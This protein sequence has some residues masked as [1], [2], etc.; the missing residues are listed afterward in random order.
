MHI[1][2]LGE[3]VSL[4]TAGGK[5]LNLCLLVEAGFNVPKGFIIATSA[6]NEYVEANGL[7]SIIDEN[8]AIIDDTV[9][10]LQTASEHIRETFTQGKMPE[11]LRKTIIEAYQRHEVDKVA[12]R[13]SATAE[14]LPETS[15]AGQQD[16][17]LNVEGKEALLRAVVDCWSSLWTPRAIGYRRRNKIPQDVVSLAVVVQAM[18]QS[19]TSGVLFTVNPLTGVRTE[20]V[21]NASFGLGE[22]LVSGRIEPDEYVVDKRSGLIKSVRLGEKDG[23]GRQGLNEEEIRE[24]V[25]LGIKIEDYYGSPQDI[26][27]ARYDDRFYVL[28]S[29]PVTGLYPLPP[30]AMPEPLLVYGSFGHVQGV[31]QSLT[32]MGIDVILQMLG[33]IQKKLGGTLS[34]KENKRFLIAGGRLYSNITELFR[35]KR[36][37]G[38]VSGVLQYVEPVMA[39]SVEEIISDSRIEK[40]DS[41]PSFHD[42]SLIV[43]VLVPF[44]CRFL[45]SVLRP[46]SSRKKMNNKI[47][48]EVKYWR[49]AGEEVKTLEEHRNYVHR[50]LE[51]IHRTILKRILPSVAAGQGMF[52]QIKMRAERLGLDNDALNI[53]RGLPYNVTTEMDLMLWEKVKHIRADPAS[54]NALKKP[55]EKL[56]DAYLKRELPVVFQTELESFLDSYGMRGVAEI[57]VGTLRWG[58]VPAHIIQMIQTYST[59][60]DPEK[61]PD[62]VFKHMAESAEASLEHITEEAKRQWG[63]RSKQIVK[64]LGV[65]QR[66]LAGL[67]ESPKLYIVK[68]LYNARRSLL[69]IGKILE[70]E[71]YLESYRDVFYLRIDELEHRDWRM[72]VTERK[73]KF[74]LDTQRNP[75]RILLSDGHAYYGSSSSDGKTLQGAPVSPGVVEGTAH[76]MFDPSSEK[77]LPG[78]ILV[79]PATD[80]AWTPLFL[81]AGGLVMEVGGLMTHGSIVAREYGIPAV[82]GVY[83]ATSRLKTGQRIRVDG[84]KGVVA[85]LE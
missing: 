22:A 37:H 23:S 82:V 36:Y 59:I 52:F 28:Q 63:W 67:R 69:S 45:G 73:Q 78:E 25:D 40:K 2:E 9:E 44:I 39:S 49:K 26:E 47:E 57:D 43:P 72:V 18:V 65:R 15:F 17:F 19:V 31:L 74:K 60:D 29:R 13:S 83:D 32:P 3:S 8:I 80:P 81:A 53:S 12:V 6:Y 24:L 30:G 62:T 64:Y 84:E 20:A 50:L 21:V 35:N 46:V 68:M 1:Y 55:V 42:M 34:P 75:P 61:A 10:S 70:S 38:I 79:C 16:T 71:G 11:T 66:N 58:E 33:Y 76:V 41:K 54:M 4:G 7:Q 85:I 5:G 51:S 14:D 77:L 48:S 27:W 56:A